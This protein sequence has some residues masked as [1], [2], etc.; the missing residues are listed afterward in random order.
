MIYRFYPADHI[1]WLSFCICFSD[2]KEHTSTKDMW[3]HFFQDI[4][5][6]QTMELRKKSSHFL[7]FAWISSRS[8]FPRLFL[9]L[10]LK[11]PPNS[12]T[13]R[14]PFPLKERLSV[15]RSLAVF[16]YGHWTEAVCFLKRS[17]GMMERS[18]VDGGKNSRS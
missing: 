14:A 17:K 16:R 13:L 11:P 8:F 4:I 2:K 5:R 18:G 1:I 6:H 3:Q 15:S 9:A 7:S 12:K 10:L